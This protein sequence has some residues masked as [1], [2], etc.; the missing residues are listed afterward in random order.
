MLIVADIR[1]PG[2]TSTAVASDI[3]ALS[4]AGYAVGLVA[5]ASS[6]LRQPRAQHASIQSLIEKGA[7]VLVPQREAVSARLCLLHHPQCFTG[8]PQLPWKIKAD[9][10]R[11]IVHHPP[12]D[13]M[14]EPYYDHA[15]INQVVTDVIG[16]AVWAPV[17]PKVRSA[18]LGLSNAPA[19]ADEDW[20][21]IIDPDLYRV[22]RQGFVPSRPIIGRHSRPDPQKWPDTRK[23]FLQAY[24]DHSGIKVRLMGYGTELD[25][26][27]GKR[28]DSWEVLSFGAMPVRSFLGSLDYFVYFHSETWIEAFGRSVLEAMAAGAVVVLPD[29]FEPLFGEGAIY[30]EPAKVADTV[31]KLHAN[32]TEYSRQ[33][34]IGPDLVQERFSLATG[35]ARVADLIGPPKKTTSYTKPGFGRGKVLYITSNGVGMGHLTRALAVARRL[36]DNIEP[37]IVS[38]SKAFGVAE[39]DGFTCEYLTYHKSIGM[40]YDRWHVHLEREVSEMLAYYRPDVFVFDGNVP[41]TGM[42]AAVAK[43]PHLWKVWQRRGMWAPGAGAHHLEQQEL[44]DAVIEPGE[45]AAAM[46]R[47]LT[48]DSNSRTIPVAPIRYLRDNEAL[49]RKEARAQLKLPQDG[50]AVL[51][52]LGSENNFD[53]SAARKQ[54]FEKLL[55]I[56]G[57]SIVNAEWL[58]SDASPA[59]PESVGRLREFPLAK[60][61]NAF[62]FAV[63]TAGYNTFHENIFAALPTIFVANENP[64]QDEQWLRAHYAELRGLSLAARSFDPYALDNALDQIL[65]EDVRHEIAQACQELDSTNG[66]DTAAAFITGQTYVRR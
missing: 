10:I 52:Q 25:A 45:L 62:D 1:F 29:H 43:S 44:F 2:G 35:V 15:Q 20:V 3:Q 46:D 57:V 56:E 51:L 7:V 14:G 59:L 17:G 34:E 54:I 13:A 66:A 64:E 31:L 11:L 50:I 37:I 28:P 42:M 38:M 40:D 41:Y 53:L 33:S 61:L 27:V 4:K 47:G 19:L 6:V 58:M 18:F 65:T 26:V 22:Q 5:V 21:N 39:T 24:P 16:P 55:P 8:Y 23:T 9:I 36:P 48:R 30:C 63:S 12:V 60:Y 49:P 32:P